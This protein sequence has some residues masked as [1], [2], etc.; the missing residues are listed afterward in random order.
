[1]PQ[2]LDLKKIPVR[3]EED[4][5]K[6]SSKTKKILKIVGISV[7]VLFLLGVATWWVFNGRKSSFTSDSIGLVLTGKNEIAS[8]E[9]LDLVL[10]YANDESV[11]LKDIEINVMYPAGF[12]FENS[13]PELQKDLKGRWTIERLA[14]GEQGEIKISGRLVGN[15]KENKIFT[16][17][18]SYTPENF[19]SKFSKE[20]ECAVS[21]A[22]SNLEINT[23]FPKI[24]NENASLKKS[25]KIK[26]AGDKPISNL[27]VKIEL[28]TGFEL[29][30]SEPAA[31]E[32]DTWNFSNIAAG[33]ETEIKL[34]GKVFGDAGSTKVFRIQAGQIDENKQFFLQNEKEVKLKIVKIDAE[35]TATANKE[36]LDGGEELEIKIHYKNKSSESLPSVVISA[37]ID[38]DLFDKTTIS[39]EGGKVEKA[40]VIWDKSMK[41]ELE[42]LAVNTEGD[43]IFRA[44][45]A[46]DIAMSSASDKNF[47]IKFKAKLTS[48]LKDLGGDVFT[49]ESDEE[50]IKLNT[51]VGYNIEIRYYDL[52]N[53]KV[54]GSGPVPPKVGQE[55]TY[56]VYLLAT[57]SYNEVRDAKIEIYLANGVN[58]A[59]SKSSSAGSLDFFDE[60]VIWDLKKMPAGIGRTKPQYQ[61]SFDISFTP[62]STMVGKVAELIEKSWFT[63]TDSFTSNLLDIKR[64]ILTTELERDLRARELGGKVVE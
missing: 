10:T 11:A 14:S 47:E 63:A 28:P 41:K 52:N 20:T 21:V 17:N 25:V 53:K 59:G 58:F 27:Q 34:D 5:K 15:P 43:L 32:L 24:L 6:M 29:S 22:K 56:K 19:N 1:M 64:G 16:A 9:K 40:R 37:D 57:N 26:N 62:T 8:G 30:Q 4:K 48:D 49:K 38:A 44:K 31:Q 45:V 35:L 50:I 2:V 33:A 42:N 61:A 3:K 12:I 55:T 7:S 23:D 46:T 13:A 18:F 51:Q 60:K 54:V 39:A 36:T